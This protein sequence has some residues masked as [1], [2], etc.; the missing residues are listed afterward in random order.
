MKQKC[1]ILSPSGKLLN[2]VKRY[3]VCPTSAKTTMPA[4]IKI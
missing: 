2:D 1:P 4:R 3:W